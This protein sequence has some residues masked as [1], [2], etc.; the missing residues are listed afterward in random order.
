M[1]IAILLLVIFMLL[2]YKNSL[3]FTMGLLLISILTLCYLTLRGYISSLTALIIVIV[4]VGA[5]I[6]LVGYIC[7]VS[8]NLY[9]EPDYS[10]LYSFL[11]LRVF[12]GL[13]S[14]ILNFNF[15][16]STINLVDYFYSSYGL[17]M[18]LFLIFM[19]FICLLIVTSHDHSP[20]GPF[21]SIK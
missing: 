1:L 16:D 4:Y 2:V 14:S 8:P 15:S 18:F 6:I 9:L 21:R 13:T 5:I 17:L 11:L 3:F 20:R 12:A 19:L 7:A 10:F